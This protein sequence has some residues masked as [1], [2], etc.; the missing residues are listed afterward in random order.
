[1]ILCFSRTG[2]PNIATNACVDSGQFS[3][4]F[5]CP[6]NDSILYLESNQKLF[7]VFLSAYWFNFGT[8]SS[9]PFS[10][11]DG[12]NTAINAYGSVSNAFSF[13]RN[14][15]FLLD[16]IVPLSIVRGF[17]FT[18]LSR[19]WYFGNGGPNLATFA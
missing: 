4:S 3:L 2:V 19:F 5:F 8:F 7:Q 18:F 14:A 15:L 11:I 17:E 1:M 16:L 13:E 6:N 10:R 9:F 12:P